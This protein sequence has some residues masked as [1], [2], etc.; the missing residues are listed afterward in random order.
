MKLATLKAQR[1]VTLVTM[2]LGNQ[3]LA[4]PTSYLR[5]ILDPLPATRVPGAGPF[6][7]QV[8]NVRGAVV[9]QANLKVAFGITDESIDPTLTADRR[10]ILVLELQIDGENA[11]VA[12][13]ADAVHEVATIETDRLEPVPAA[14]SEW[15]PE[16]LTGLYR[17]QDGFVLLP[18]LPAIFA[19][20]VSRPVV[21]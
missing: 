5:E 4:L 17:G 10:R 11:M 21:A 19:T 13:E 6:V 7:P 14:A 15:P 9:P 2:A 1:T 8:V 3:T 20:Q 18:D 12:I 16:Y